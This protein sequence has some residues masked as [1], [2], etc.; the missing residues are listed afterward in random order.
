M[1]KQELKVELLALL[2]DKTLFDEPCLNARKEALDSIS[3]Y[4]QILQIN[5]W[6]GELAAL[7]RKAVELRDQFQAID[8]Q[9]FQRVRAD[10][11]A[12]NYTRDGL[13]ALLDQFADYAPDQP[14][15]PGYEYNGLDTFL[16]QVIFTTTFPSES[17]ERDPEM[18]RYE[19]TPARIIL[20]LVDSL[21][22]TPDD[23]FIDLGSGLG[24]VVMLVNLLTGVPSVGIEYDP[25]YCE[26]ARSCA[27]ALNLKNVTFIQTD[28]RSADLNSGTIFYLF[29][30]FVNEIF[31][32]VLERLRYTAIRHNI[33]ICSYGTI[34]FDLAKLP[35]LQIRDPAMEH[36]FKLAI[37]TSKQ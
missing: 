9:L 22:L 28:A 25:A 34:T 27:D 11:L 7:Y 26:F 31:K 24:L 10:L 37:F 23:V 8:A 4:G 36:D 16:E 12:G 14:S 19:A 20:E 3:Y 17:R 1:D 35:W 6:Q 33:Y 13:R 15:Q 29:T 21:H 5:H 32:S 2:N 30:P 18:I